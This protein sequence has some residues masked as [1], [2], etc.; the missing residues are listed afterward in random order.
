MS[1]KLELIN[2]PGNYP[3]ITRGGVEIAFIKDGKA[4][5][6]AGQER[7]K[8]QA[9]TFWKAYTQESPAGAIY[10]ANA[11]LL[12][13]TQPYVKTFD[14]PGTIDVVSDIP[15]CPPMNPQMGTKTPEVAAWFKQYHPEKWASM[16]L[17]WR[18]R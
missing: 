11:E 10:K 14:A 17:K 16:H 18:D 6:I 4:E 8:I 2:T 1:A 7:F 5:M 3:T 13:A 12:K 9:R 15:T